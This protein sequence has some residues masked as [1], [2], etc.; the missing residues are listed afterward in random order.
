MRNV[1]AVVH[2]A[3]E[4]LGRTA[5]GMEYCVPVALAC[6]TL[7]GSVVV[8]YFASDESAS[9]AVHSEIIGLIAAVHFETVEHTVFV[10]VLRFVL[11]AKTWAV[12][13]RFETVLHSVFAVHSVLAA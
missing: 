3:F 11:A 1:A 7:F 13:A 9:T 12:A 2:I 8:G 6:H 5:P 10:A 4:L